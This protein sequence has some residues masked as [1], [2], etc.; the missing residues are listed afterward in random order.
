MPP[1]TRSS[2]ASR[3]FLLAIIAATG[4][5]AKAIFVKL[6]YLAGPTD[7]VTV[8]T[9]RM[10]FALPVFAW[11][12]WTSSRKADAVKLNRNEWFMVIGLGFLGYYLSSLFDFM[13]LQYLS[14]GMERLI[15]FLYPTLTMM[16]SALMLK[17][18]ISR[19]H[20]AALAISYS[21][22]TLAF[23]DQLPH[24]GSNLWLGAGLVFASTLTYSAYLTGASHAISRIGSQRF[25]ALSMLSATCF[26][27]L[28]FLLTHPVQALAQPI[29]VYEATLGMAAFST[30]IPMF[31]LSAA[32]R[33]IQPA[34]TA[35]IG[36]LGPVATIFM[37][38]A[39][40]G[41]TITWGQMAGS[42]MV[43]YG[44]WLIGHPQS[45]KF[46]LKWQRRPNRNT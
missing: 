7:P 14:A 37:A 12:A 35:I 16:M 3:G 10:L 28:Q 43:L 13:G 38:W 34:K 30:I 36:S 25:T 29:G 40:L 42:V 5:S 26:V 2:H 33:L 6:A 21:G 11:V 45:A 1:A 19:T 8:L 17:H 32:I 41:E 23:L 9:L 24:H 31:A 27:V 20:I 39:I 4:F 44:V 15:L 22:I 46:F 18:A